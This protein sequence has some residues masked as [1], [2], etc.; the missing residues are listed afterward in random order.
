MREMSEPESIISS[1]LLAADF[2][3]PEV[4]LVVT[5]ASGAGVQYAP[6]GRR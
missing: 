1:R 3:P 6:T 2:L 4:S 5:F